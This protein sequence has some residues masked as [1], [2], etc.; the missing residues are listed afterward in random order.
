MGKNSNT[1][2]SIHDPTA[3]EGD[4]VITIK[5][6][7]RDERLKIKKSI[8]KKKRAK[9]G[10]KYKNDDD[11][12]KLMDFVEEQL[13]LHKNELPV[14]NVDVDYVEID[15]YLLAGKH[16]EEYKHVFANFKSAKIEEED[17]EDDDK[18]FFV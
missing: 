15:E 13:E 8:K 2:N 7:T 6:I 9:I 4:N 12:E 17:N 10:I 16:Y 18:V 3:T 1:E 14:P 11:R 5:K